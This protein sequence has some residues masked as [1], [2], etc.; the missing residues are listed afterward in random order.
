[1]DVYH[2]GKMELT[3]KKMLFNEA[4]ECADRIRAGINN[5]RKDVVELHDREGWS[6][7]G[8][9]TWTACVQTEFA[10]AERYIF[11][12]FKAAEI[13]QNIND[14]A[15]SNCTMVQLGTIPERQLRPLA[16]LEPAQQREAWQR[17]V[18]TS[19][20]GKVTAA[21]VSQVVKGMTT[22][23]AATLPPHIVTEAMG[24]VTFIISH[25]GRI[26]E[27]DPLRDAALIKI[28]KWC[29]ENISERGK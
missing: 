21:I 10:Q 11:Y 23:A 14:S 22:P 26:R 20:D 25:L 29:N 12:Q 24:I 9:V 13:E 16:K 15:K 19:P 4:R 28:I 18:A 3:I 5:I 6:A 17:A 1:M 27:D 8:Y 2:G 7:L